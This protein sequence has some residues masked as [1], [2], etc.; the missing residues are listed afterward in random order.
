MR[1]LK[2]TEGKGLAKDRS[3]ND[4][5]GDSSSWVGIMLKLGFLHRALCFNTMTVL[6]LETRSQD[7]LSSISS[8]NSNLLGERRDGWMDG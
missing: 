3:R 7:L 8:T 4:R 5:C 6:R 1:K 2:L